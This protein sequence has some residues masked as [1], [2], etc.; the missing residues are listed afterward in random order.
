MTQTL[1]FLW[2]AGCRKPAE[3]WGVCFCFTPVWM[4]VAG[5]G[6]GGAVPSGDPTWVW[7]L[8]DRGSWCSSSLC[9]QQGEGGGGGGRKTRGRD[10]PRGLWVPSGGD[11][12]GCSGVQEALLGQGEVWLNPSSS[13]AVTWLVDVLLFCCQEHLNFSCS[14]S[15]VGN[16]L[17]SVRH[18]Q[19]KEHEHLLVIIR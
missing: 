3:G 12:R 11:Q 17:L 19:E 1:T 4:C 7:R 14:S 6:E 8:L 9:S 13:F 15:S 10:R 16:L 2:F 18:E 5:V